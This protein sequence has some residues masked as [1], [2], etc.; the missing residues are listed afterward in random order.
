MKKIICLGDSITDAGRLFSV[1]GLGEGYVGQLQ[2]LVNA[3]GITCTFTNRGVDGFTIARL[4]ETVG[5]DCQGQNPDLVTML[6]G[7]NDI[8]VLMNTTVDTCQRRQLLQEFIK[9]YGLL[10]TKLRHTTKARLFLLEPFIFPWPREYANW[11]P[12]LDELTCA[13]KEYASAHQAV[14]IPLQAPLEQLA[15]GD[16]DKVT[17]DGI[18]LTQEGHRLVA[19]ALFKALLEHSLEGRT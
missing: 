13:M 3:R 10:L 16:W 17:V 19:G 2:Q 8:G 11:R 14:W 9:E 1:N 5:R 4:L 12:Y 6:I 7:V 15:Q 18:H